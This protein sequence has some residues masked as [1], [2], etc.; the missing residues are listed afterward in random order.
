MKNRKKCF[1]LCA[2]LFT[3]YYLPLTTSDL[4]A[5]PQIVGN[6]NLKPDISVSNPVPITVNLDDGNVF[7]AGIGSGNIVKFNPTTK[8]LLGEIKQIYGI[9]NLAVCDN[10]LYVSG[11]NSNWQMGIHSLNGWIFSMRLSGNLLYYGTWGKLYS[12]NLIDKTQQ[13]VIDFGSWNHCVSC[14]NIDSQRNCLYVTVYDYNSADARVVIFDL[15][16]NQIVATVSIGNN[17]FRWDV[18]YDAAFD[19]VSKLFI[20]QMYRS[21][22][23]VVDVVN[24]TLITN[25]PN[26]NWPQ[27][28]T[29]DT[30]KKR[31]YVVDNYTDRFHIIN[32]ETH[33]LLKQFSPG[34]D[35][36]G[37]C[38]DTV[39]NRVYTAN[40]WSHDIGI[41]DSVTETLIDRVLF[42]ANSPLDVS[43]TLDKLYISNGQSGGI[44]VIDKNTYG[45]LDKI[46]PYS[47]YDTGMF[48]YPCGVLNIFTGELRTNSQYAYAVDKFN[49]SIAVF[50]I[51]QGKFI[52]HINPPG[53]VTAITK[54]G[55]KIYVAFNDSAKLYFGVIVNNKIWCYS[56]CSDGGISYGL[57]VNSKT[58]KAY[59][60]DYNNN[61]VIVFDLLTNS[62]KKE[63]PTAAF[64][65]CV[66]IEENSNTVYVT[67]YG[68]DCV[69]VIDG[70]TDTLIGYIPVGDSPWGIAVNSLSK[71]IYVVNTVD[72]TLTIINGKNNAVVSTLSIGEGARYVRCDIATQRVYVPNQIDQTVTVVEDLVDTT[73]PEPPTNLVAVAVGSGDAIKLSWQASTS[74]DTVSYCIYRIDISTLSSPQ[75][76]TSST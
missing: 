43:I 36:S 33:Q 62:V 58:Q 71:R 50:D 32:T 69:S 60:A 19:G 6:I 16:T 73:P 74:A 18:R 20:T 70:D 11:Y 15:I 30:V 66:A 76:V 57:E 45:V 24:N 51:F 64:P 61:K 34:D 26:V 22:I 38:V 46:I 37:V 42:T 75:P 53:T 68:A 12:V 52:K 25:I 7:V 5:S 23:S 17:P 3:I 39:R 67:N 44:F 8:K 49:N 10:K 31:L 35:P 55:D 29:I 21:E 9:W 14:M 2:L 28:L 56:Q 1:T 48:L 4:L 54:S 13:V 47:Y 40:Y 72:K 65:A 59:I 63:I 41:V 27:K